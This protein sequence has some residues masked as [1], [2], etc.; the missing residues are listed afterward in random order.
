MIHSIILFV[1]L[2]VGCFTNKTNLIWIAFII[3]V[4]QLSLLVHYIIT[5][6]KM[7]KV[8]LDLLKFTAKNQCSD[9]PLQM[10]L[11][12]FEVEFYKDLTIVKIGLSFTI[13]G[14]ITFFLILVWLSQI[15][16]WCSKRLAEKKRLVETKKIKSP[17][18]GPTTEKPVEL[19]LE[20]MR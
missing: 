17:S 1:I 8:D 14:L 12:N 5:H 2:I 18:D 20:R 3:F 7:S 15:I 16:E 13:I 9:G 19:Q 6:V 10:A 4:V 11:E